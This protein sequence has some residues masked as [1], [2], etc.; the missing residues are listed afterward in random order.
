MTALSITDSPWF[1]I[2]NECVRDPKH[3]GKLRA[4][5]LFRAGMFDI[6]NDTSHDGAMSGND[7][8][9][10]RL[11]VMRQEQA[12]SLTEVAHRAGIS[13][14][15]LSQ[16][17]HG[18][19]TTPSHEVLRRLATAL[20]T[21]ITDLTGT[22]DTWQPVESEQLPASLRAFAQGARLPQADVAMLAGIHYRGKQPGEPDDWAHIYETIK[23]TIR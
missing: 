18:A 11:R 12:L 15:Y 8:L 6:T 20:G 13:K 2:K 17:E 1:W 10:A 14:A 23:R 22:P 7:S 16:L 9:G 19:S 5:Q 4:C 21:S 3:T